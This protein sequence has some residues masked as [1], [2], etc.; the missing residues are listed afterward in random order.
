LHGEEEI[1]KERR[2]VRIVKE[3]KSKKKRN[4]NLVET[5]EIEIL[6]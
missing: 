1:V 6:R 4:V 5:V 3:T 2:V